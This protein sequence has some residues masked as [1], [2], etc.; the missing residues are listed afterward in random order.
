MVA[1]Y[2]EAKPVPDDQGR[3]CL[4]KLVEAHRLL[5]AAWRSQMWDRMNAASNAS[6]AGAGAAMDT[7]S[8]R[9][10]LEEAAAL[11]AEVATLLSPREQ[12]G[13]LA[14]ALATAKR[15]WTLRPQ[16]RAWSQVVRDVHA[17]LRAE[18]ELWDE[19]QLADLERI[20]QDDEEALHA[21]GVGRSGRARRVLLG[22]GLLLLP[23][24]LFFLWIGLAATR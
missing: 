5:D 12:A 18:L 20:D 4:A 21:A 7:A 2:R 19:P 9:N 1:P 23:W 17:S 24:V 13:R 6:L 14:E 10:E 15:G 3:A 16:A 8:G 22:V 11:M